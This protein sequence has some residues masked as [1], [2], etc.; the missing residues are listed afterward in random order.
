MSVKK[1]SKKAVAKKVISKP[2]VKAVKKTVV[3]PKVMPPKMVMPKVQTMPMKK[4]DSKKL[5]KPLIFL[6]ILAAVYL[7]KD[8][9]IVASV[10]GKPV[11]R[12][13]LTRNLEKQ[14]ASTVLE[15]MTLQMLVEQELKKAGI[16]VTDEEMDA[17]ISKIEE[18][19]A[20]QGQNLDDLLAA[21]NLTRT[22]V[23]EQLA[24]S[25]GMEKLL[26]G[27]IIVTGEEIT[28]YFEQNKEMMGADVALEDIKADIE[29]QLRQE[30]L[31]TEQQKWF[32]EIKK[33]AKINYFKFAPSTSL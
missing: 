3:A 12:W 6:L 24:L 7:L 31:A 20:A 1:T 22:T 9:V 21:Q 25:K 4:L 26:A 10:N 23:R 14:S 16:E 29:A 19:L 27:N 11:T 15:N 8:E 2:A 28:A 33:N 17:E 13:A 5:I 30:K 18:Q 32:A